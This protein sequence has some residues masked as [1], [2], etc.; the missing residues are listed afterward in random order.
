MSKFIEYLLEAAAFFGAL[1][2]SCYSVFKEE[3][4]AD[5]QVK[6]QLED[7]DIQLTAHKKHDTP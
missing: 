5:L 3:G 7:V 2:I 1:A 6:T 4:N